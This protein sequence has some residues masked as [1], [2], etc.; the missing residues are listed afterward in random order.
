V[1]APPYFANAGSAHVP[2]S[3]EII[4][5]TTTYPPRYNAYQVSQQIPY[6]YLETVS[7]D[8]NM[9]FPA[10]S[11]N[12]LSYNQ[13]SDTQMP[14]NEA[15]HDQ[16]AQLD[17]GQRSA[18]RVVLPREKVHSSRYARVEVEPDSMTVISLEELAKPTAAKLSG[19]S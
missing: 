14:Y 13:P 16:P 7:D 1:P 6:P 19:E 3:D 12:Q 9:P 2:H 8:H 15:P 5:V 17:T 18:A 11:H 10:P 4:S